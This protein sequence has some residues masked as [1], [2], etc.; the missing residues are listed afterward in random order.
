[1]FNATKKILI[2]LLLLVLPITSAIAANSVSSADT[3]IIDVRTEAEWNA[4]HL[5][6]AILIPHDRIETGISKVVVDKKAAIYLYCRTGRRTA[7]AVGFLK[8]SGYQNL[9]NLETLE[10]ASR[11]LGRRIV[12]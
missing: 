3:F 5:E 2:Q 7:L 12:Q 4:G 11:V 1:M 10:N 8:K 6:G 9:S